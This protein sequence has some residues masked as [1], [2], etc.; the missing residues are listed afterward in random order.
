MVGRG[1][2]SV[3]KNCQNTGIR[4]TPEQNVK[5]FGSDF[6]CLFMDGQDWPPTKAVEKFKPQIPY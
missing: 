1:P 4:K 2:L 6:Q 5:P 3:H